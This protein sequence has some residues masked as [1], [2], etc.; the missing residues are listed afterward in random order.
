MPYRQD[1]ERNRRE[2]E[3]CR[4]LAALMSDPAVR[5]RLLDIA[6]TYDTLAEQIVALKLSP[7]KQD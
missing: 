6:S 3:R 4:A 5:A 7:P 1:A 2:A